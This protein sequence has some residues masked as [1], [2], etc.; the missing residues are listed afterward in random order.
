MPALPGRDFT[1]SILLIVLGKL[2]TQ[3]AH[4]T[5]A[6]DIN[7]DKA[8]YISRAINFLELIKICKYVV[9][10]CDNSSHQYPRLSQ[11]FT[12]LVITAPRLKNELK[13]NEAPFT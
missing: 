12:I 3:Y 5:R 8:D 10:V 4:A 7:E 1:I 6:K 9:C 2:A 11:D 13:D